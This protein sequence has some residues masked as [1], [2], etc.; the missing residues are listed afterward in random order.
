[1]TANTFREE[2]PKGIKR[3][4]YAHKRRIRTVSSLFTI[5]VI[6]CSIIAVSYYFVSQS[7]DHTPPDGGN[8]ESTNHS[9]RA[10]LIDALYVKFPRDEFTNSLNSTLR[11]AGFEVD[12]Y[13]GAAVTVDFLRSL[14]EGYELI[15]L[16]MHSALSDENELYLFTAEPYSIGKYTQEQNY[17][18][19]KEAYA[20]E[21]A[22]PVFAVNW[23][24]VRRCMTGKFNNTLVVAMGCD[25]TCDQSL[26][27]EMMSQGAMGYVGWNGPVTISHS[28]KATLCLVKASYIDKL[29]LNLAVESTNNLVGR[30]PSC[31]TFLEYL[32]SS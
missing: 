15:I 28:D 19:I 29:P 14:P 6:I 2:R 22:S 24:F 23:G 32:P 4:V 10:A 13:Q 9:L 31:E 18:L 5:A 27:R 26:A 12:F 3:E 16:R 1:M 11:A 25:G 8:G 20:S 21:D 17:R 7:S 30:D